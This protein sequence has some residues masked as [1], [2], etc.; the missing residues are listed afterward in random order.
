MVEKV[1]MAEI[2][3]LLRDMEAAMGK[4][5]Q[6]GKTVDQDRGM[7]ERTVLEGLVV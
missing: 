1:G 7:R 5:A 4:A 6:Q 2:L 3:T